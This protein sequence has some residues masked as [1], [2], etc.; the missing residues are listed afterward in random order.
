VR[1][2]AEPSR[3]DAEAV[4]RVSEA[5]YRSLVEAS[6][7]VVWTTDP[8]GRFVEAQF[9][10]EAYTGQPWSEHAGF[11]WAEMVHPDDRRRV[12]DRW[13]EAAATGDTYEVT[14]RVRHAGTGTWRWCDVRA[15]PVKAPDGVVVE[16]VGTLTDVGDRRI[17]EQRA[18]EAAARMDALLR[19]APIGLAFFDRDLRYVMLNETLAEING[20]PLDEHVGRRVGEVVPAVGEVTDRLFREV[21]ETGDAVLD[22]EISGETPARPGEPRDWV[23]NYFPVR[24]DRGELMGI[25]ATVV[26]VTERKQ[27]EQR[28]TEERQVV[29]TLHWVGSILSAELDLGRLVQAVTDAATLLTGAQFGAFFYNVVDEGGERYQLYTISG[30]SRDAFELFDMPRNTAIFAPTFAGESVIRLADVTA[31]PRYGQMP[32]HH[33]IPEGHLPVRSYLAV[34]VVSR[35]GDVLGGLFFG[36]GKPG[37]FDER[38]EQL[39]VGIAAQAAV[40][41]DNAALY[42][43]VS[44]AERRQALLATASAQLTT[45]LERREVLR[46]LTDIVVP[47]LADVC[48]VDLLE[49][50][51]RLRRFINSNGAVPREVEKAIERRPFSLDGEHPVAQVLRSGRPRLLREVPDDLLGRL[52]TDDDHL[53]VARRFGIR[54]AMI[55]PLVARDQAIGVLS[56]VATTD[57]RRFDQSDL[58]L[59][60]DLAGRTAVALDNARLYDQQREAALLLQRSLLPPVASPFAGMEVAVRY[61]PGGEGVETGGD[62]YDV[63]RLPSGRVGLALGDVMGRGI[64]AAA[65]MGQLRNGLRAYLLDERGPADA[66]TRLE[67]FADP[68][69]TFV[70][71]I[72]A[73]L[74]P[75]TREMCV[76]NAGHVPPLLVVAGLDVAYLDVPL[77]PPLG[78]VVGPPIE[79]GTVTLP[80][81]ATLVLFTDGLVE[82][83]DQPVDVGLDRLRVVAEEARGEPDLDVFTDALLAGMLG[84]AP[85]TDDVAVLV[86]RLPPA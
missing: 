20:V 13:A 76:A 49:P 82:R 21:I 45:S 72:C 32:P 14:T 40:G 70:T 65:R 34:P 47:E 74:D 38:D 22:I 24:D 51:G 33:G 8:D 16:W 52:A 64:P 78:T 4:L 69:R 54:S 19:T 81:G 30:V 59:A 67:L 86:L 44:R 23:V 43:A 73:V 57:E 10:W 27:A 79:E 50:D 17:A 62:W 55:V 3:F 58:E 53:A 25:G 39:A 5:R 35:S 85:N 68:E 7:A 56:L 42:E 60:E 75:V 37:V 46:R 36:H 63:V 29:E 9:S 6:V 31:D 77:S 2:V 28:L 84:S 61:L 1:A 12:L 15:A 41:M 80:A 83:R 18:A 11:G 48:E 26:D 71:T 66:L